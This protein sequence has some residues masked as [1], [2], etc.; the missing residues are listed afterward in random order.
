[1]KK[2]LIRGTL[3]SF[4][5][6]T[7]LRVA[8]LRSERVKP[9]QTGSNRVKPGQ[10]GSNRVKPGQ[11]KIKPNS[12]LIRPNQTKSN[13]FILGSRN[14]V[15]QKLPVVAAANLLLVEPIIH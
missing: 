5:V 12:N 6:A 9:G 13:L 4:E 8:A 15:R 10:T 7:E 1:M 11:T 2:C 3:T 14:K